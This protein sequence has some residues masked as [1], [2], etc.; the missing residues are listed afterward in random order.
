MRRVSPLFIFLGIALCTPVAWAQGAS[1]CPPG[2]WFCADVT[3]P[4]PAPSTEASPPVAPPPGGE[5][6]AVTPSEGTTTS[7]NGTTI[8]T[9]P[10]NGGTTII[11]NTAPPAA[12][13]PAAQPPMRQS[14]PPP[15]PR[16]VLPPPRYEPLPPP[17]PRKHR[18]EWGFNMRLVGALMGDR[19][20][21]GRDDKAGMGGLGFS[22]RARPTG[23]FALDLGLDFI[24]GV[25]YQGNKRSEVPFTVNAM[26]FVNPR[27]KTQVYFLGGIGWSSA[28]VELA[29]DQIAHYSYFG[30]Q[31]G[32]GLEF[33]VA[34]QVGIDVDLLGFIRGRT[35]SLA[36]KQPEFIDKDTGR[37]TNTS[38][39]GLLRGGV[40]IY[41]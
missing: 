16:A 19:R 7:T 34:R 32:I 6:K 4:G 21:E 33:R 41:W 11:V 1:N 5:K 12:Q 10:S 29:P 22:L 35:D 38:G 14:P 31:G 27:S 36:E 18:S 20:N 40:V 25:D 37:T 3:V 39:G 23:H 17:P 8:Q 13:P 15:P 30:M 24:G 2:S 9:A 28:Q 26:L